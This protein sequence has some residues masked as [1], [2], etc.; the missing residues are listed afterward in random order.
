MRRVIITM[1][2]LAFLSSGCAARKYENTQLVGM[3]DTQVKVHSSESRPAIDIGYDG[4]KLLVVKTKNIKREKIQARHQETYKRCWTVERKISP[5]PNAGAM[6]NIMDGLFQLPFAI[7]Q[8]V[9]FLTPKPGCETYTN[10]TSWKNQENLRVTET[11]YSGKVSLDCGPAGQY[12]VT[13]NEIGTASL[14]IAPLL[15]FLTKG[16]SW[17]I[18]A[19]TY[20]HGEL[21][22]DS[23][24]LDTT[25][26]GVTW[27][28]PRYQPDLPPLLVASVKFNDPNNNQILDAKET[29]YIVVTL[30]NKGRGDA[31]RIEVDPKLQ[32][33]VDGVVLTPDKK[34]YIELLSKG[35]SKKLKFKLNAE[36][37][38]PAQRLRIK[39]SIKELNGF[40]PPP[41]EVNLATRPYAPPKLALVSWIVDDDNV[42]MS[43]GNGNDRL[44][45]GE[46]AEITVFIQNIGQG[47]AENVRATLEVADSNLFSKELR[48]NLGEILPGE[49]QKAVFTLRV[50]NRYNGP[51]NLPISITVTERRSMFGFRQKLKLA[52]GKM[53]KQ[54][55]VINAF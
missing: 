12:K 21:I 13:T 48:T 55:G 35:E 53:V 5:S 32:G 29:A 22:G 49:W 50:N 2:L 31:F 10:W 51:E 3:G 6:A 11:P 17:T 30:T 9:L 34:L 15:N 46:Q 33:Q 38:I 24:T 39:I 16:Y 44:E 54:S 47:L 52:L 23:L 4:K 28:K 26:L 25:Q 42:G 37:K 45:L 27:N 18:K 1:S 14:N 40:E 43:S 41:L 7:L 8:T 20:C 36:E 19:K